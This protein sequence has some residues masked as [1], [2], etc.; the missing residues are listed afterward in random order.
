MSGKNNRFYNMQVYFLKGDRIYSENVA[1][2]NIWEKDDGIFFDIYVHRL[3]KSF[4]FDAVFIKEIMD[5]NGNV[6]YK[7]VEDFILDYKISATEVEKDEYLRPV[8]S[9]STVLDRIRNDLI[10]LIFMADTWGKDIRIKDK[11]IYDYIFKEVAAAQNFSQQYIASY[12]SKIQPEAEDFY[13]ALKSLKS[14]SPKQA[15]KL[16]K[17]IV[18]ICRA[19]GEMHYNERMYLADILYILRE[20]GLKIPENLI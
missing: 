8:K 5:L 13:E 10:M 17:E 6:A 3:K 19:D 9:E 16:L 1:I 18:K 4:V 14:K 12:V 11:I 20:N 15:E 7:S 2:R